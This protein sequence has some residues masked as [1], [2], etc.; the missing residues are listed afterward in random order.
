MLATGF[1]RNT[2]SNREGG[3]DLEEFRVEQVVDRTAL[4]GIGWM[5]LTVGCARCHDHKYDPMTQ[6]DFYRLY[7]ILDQ[8]DEVNIDAPLEGEAE[9][10]HSTYADYRRKRDELT[11]PIRDEL[12]ALQARWEARMLQAGARPSEDP[13]WD[14]QWEVLG[15]VWGGQLG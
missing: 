15:L 11:A 5:G 7:A 10:F 4:V 12:E 3:A 2:L 6:S 9:A 8:A 13:L 14:R 1:L